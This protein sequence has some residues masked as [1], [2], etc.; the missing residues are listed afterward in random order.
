MYN[1]WTLESKSSKN[2][3]LGVLVEQGGNTLG[4][5]TG[6]WSTDVA[7]MWGIVPKATWHW[8]GDSSAAND[9]F[10]APDST[11]WYVCLPPARGSAGCDC[12][13][14]QFLWN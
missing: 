4:R 8:D 12:L 14:P 3:I 9:P 6:L 1:A 7:K 5:Q 10:G 13:I 2:R 11:Q